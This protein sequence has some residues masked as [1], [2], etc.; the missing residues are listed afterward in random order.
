MAKKENTSVKLATD[1]WRKAK[2]IAHS[3]GVHM[4]T[5]LS[6]LL[7]PLVNK[8]YPK[9]LQKLAEEDEPKKE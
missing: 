8:D 7:R 9:A 4:S 1:V 5:Y 3:K 6:D 2:V